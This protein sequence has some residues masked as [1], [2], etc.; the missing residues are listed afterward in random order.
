MVE[1]EK[2]ENEKLLLENLLAVDLPEEGT[3][4]L[5]VIGVYD[6]AGVEKKILVANDLEYHRQIV[7]GYSN[8]LQCKQEGLQISN[9]YGGGRVDICADKI[10]AYAYSGSYGMAPQKLVEELLRD[11]CVENSKTLEVKMGKLR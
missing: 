7:N 6:N 9:V 8:D 1:N 3:F 10:V 11:Y 2:N 5:V 4:K